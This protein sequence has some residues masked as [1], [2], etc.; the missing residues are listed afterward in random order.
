MLRTAGGIA[1][2]VVI[3]VGMTA[4]YISSAP[5]PGSGS[6]DDKDEGE[7]ERVVV[8]NMQD[9]DAGIIKHGIQGLTPGKVTIGHDLPAGTDSSIKPIIEAGEGDN[10]VIITIVEEGG[11]K[12]LQYEVKTT[13]GAGIDLRYAAFGFREGDEI[14][15]TGKVDSIGPADSYIQPNFKVGAEEGH[16][17]KETANGPFEW[18]IELTAA[19]LGEIK[20]GNPA[21]I[22]IDGRR[23]SGGNGDPTG[24]KVIITQILIEGDRPVNVK[25]LAAPVVTVAGNVV[26]WD[27]IDGASGYEVF[28]GTEKISTQTTT[29][30]NLLAVTTLA[31]GAYA[32]T[33]VAV[34][35]PGST[36]N[37]DPSAAVNA[38]KT[39]PPP[40][41]FNL[42]VNSATQSSVVKGTG[43][44]VATL[45]GDGGY[46]VTYG[47]DQYDAAY[48]Y[49]EV[50]FGAGKN[51]SDYPNLTLKWKGLAGDVGWKSFMVHVQSTAFTGSLVQANADAT[52]NCNS[53][54]DSDV[55]ITADLSS[56]SVTAQKVYV[57]VTIRAAATGTL[58]GAGTTTAYEVFDVSFAP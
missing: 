17:F 38:T 36:S 57:A 48:S 8:F 5:L 37:S 1:L 44:T 56:V 58:G 16:G 50:D 20:G 29:T 51:I 9:S 54:N 4:C 40:P 12:A 10:H 15:I 52:Q 35:T 31:D 14:T 22:R 55:S 39:T 43:T 24:Q 26:S 32:I 23:G 13:W 3:G 6:D 46:S 34:G 25:K 41:T 2:A 27:A 49:F 21:G 42:T 28:A 7:M 53:Q 45:A 18:K 33:V 11:K 19:M 30:L 47:A